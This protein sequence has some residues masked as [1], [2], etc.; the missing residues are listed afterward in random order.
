[1]RQVAQYPPSSGTSCGHEDTQ[2]S[3]ENR[4]IAGREGDRRADDVTVVMIDP[5]PNIDMGVVVLRHGKARG[6]RAKRGFDGE[7]K[8]K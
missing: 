7:Q 1:V 6:I 3:D 5:W 4:I 2:E 8:S